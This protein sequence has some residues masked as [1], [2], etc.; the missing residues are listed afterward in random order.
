M[1]DFK[2]LAEIVD[3]KIWIKIGH[4]TWSYDLIDIAAEGSRRKKNQGSSADKLTA[5]MPGKITKVFVKN[6]EQVEKGQPLLVMEAMKMEYTLKADFATT[7]KQVLV[8]VGEQVM[9]GQHLI[10]LGKIDQDGKS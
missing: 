3:Q 1:S 6:E 7:V 8:K 9:L 10:E 5:L 2:Y 4:E